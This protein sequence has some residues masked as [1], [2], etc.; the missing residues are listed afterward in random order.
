MRDTEAPTDWIEARKRLEALL[1]K[2]APVQGFAPGIPWSMH[3]RA[4]AVYCKKWSPQPALIDLEGRGCRGGFGIGELDDF[5]P[6][7]R[8]Q[9]GVIEH[10]KDLD[11][12]R[13]ALS[14]AD[15][16][17]ALEAENAR[18]R[19]GLQGMVDDWQPHGGAWLTRARI[20]LSSSSTPPSAQAP[21]A[22]AIGAEP[23]PM[24]LYCPACGVQHIDAPEWTVERRPGP[25][26]RAIHAAWT[27]PPHRSH[28]CGSCGCIWRPADVATTGVEAIQTR[29]KADTFDNSGPRAELA[30]PSSIPPDVEALLAEAR[31][32]TRLVRSSPQ[33]P[34]APGLCDIIDRLAAALAKRKERT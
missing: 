33:G 18:L 11:D 24:V 10:V 12:I 29:G 20:L 1:E 23:I 3:L 5:I 26:D 30:K 27:N 34:L 17:D 13:L 6:G 14:R 22:G 4:Y 31:E 21:P 25:G 16:I 15:R 8:D 9:L 28:L 32:V 2:R 7:W 19:E